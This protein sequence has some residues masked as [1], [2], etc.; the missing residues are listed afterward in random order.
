MMMHK[1]LHPGDDID[2]LYVSKKEGRRST[3][4]E[5]DDSKIT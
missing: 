4:I 1:V 5:Y 3:H 2:R